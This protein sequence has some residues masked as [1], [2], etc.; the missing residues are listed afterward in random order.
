MFGCANPRVS[1]TLLGV[2]PFEKGAAVLSG[3]EIHSGWTSRRRGTPLILLPNT[4]LQ[5]PGDGR[6]EASRAE[7]GT[8][9]VL[10]DWGVELPGEG[11]G[12]GVLTP[13]QVTNL[14]NKVGKPLSP[15]GLA[16]R[17]V[18]S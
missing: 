7:Y 5:G 1:G 6:G 13:Q 9:S 17:E 4:L 16:G 18:F 14:K 11:F 12:L 8:D 3:D 2:H 10:V 15:A